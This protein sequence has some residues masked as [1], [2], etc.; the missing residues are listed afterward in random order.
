MIPLRSL[1]PKDIALATSIALTKIT[2]ISLERKLNSNEERY[3]GILN[4][5]HSLA[6]TELYKG[7]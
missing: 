4:T 2:D 1:A 3:I 6:L 5:L 7:E